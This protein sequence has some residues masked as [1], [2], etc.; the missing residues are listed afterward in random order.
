MGVERQETKIMKR[1]P[2]GTGQAALNCLNDWQKTGER[3]ASLDGGDI[4][5][6]ESRNRKRW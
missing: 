4:N 1:F 5:I 6:I 3:R 2:R